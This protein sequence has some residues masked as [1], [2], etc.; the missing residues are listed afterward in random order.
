MASSLEVKVR[1]NYWRSLT[2]RNCPDPHPYLGMVDELQ[3]ALRDALYLIH[4]L[5]TPQ[6]TPLRWRGEWVGKKC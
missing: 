6:P 3:V 1:L 4:S 5:Q 2:R